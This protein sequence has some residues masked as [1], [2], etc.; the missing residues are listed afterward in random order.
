MIFLLEKMKKKKIINYKMIFLKK[1]E[2]LKKM[3]NL[4]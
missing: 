1:L 3:K 4:N 2:I